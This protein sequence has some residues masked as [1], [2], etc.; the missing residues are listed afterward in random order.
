[1]SYLKSVNVFGVN[2][3]E[4]MSTIKNVHVLVEDST[5]GFDF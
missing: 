3:L 5:S 2:D 1:M 4:S